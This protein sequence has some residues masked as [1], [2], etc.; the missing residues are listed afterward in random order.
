ML[1]NLA[2][3]LFIWCERLVLFSLSTRSD[4]L[5]LFLVRHNSPKSNML[6][7]IFFPQ[8]IIACRK[9]GTSIEDLAEKFPDMIIKVIILLFYFWWFIIVIEAVSSSSTLNCNRHVVLIGAYWC[10]QR[11]NWWRC[12]KG[13]W[14]FGSHSGW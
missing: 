8:L 9:G 1:S 6:L 11:N 3:Y 2:S 12:H 7:H 13:C 4:S 5:S 14:W 10:F